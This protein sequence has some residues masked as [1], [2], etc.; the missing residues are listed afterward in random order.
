MAGT[1]LSVLAVCLLLLVLRA[2][3]R[4]QFRH[5]SWLFLGEP[6]ASALDFGPSV[7]AIAHNGGDTDESLA[8]AIAWDA[9][10]VEFDVSFLGGKLDVAHTPPRMTPFFLRA[11]V[12]RSRRLAECWDALPDGLAVYL[13]AKIHTGRSARALAMFL[14]ARPGRRVFV[15]A[16]N[17]AFLAYLKRLH[18][19]ALT[20]LSVGRRQH[21][22]ARRL[23]GA[24]PEIDAVSL[25]HARLLLPEVVSLCHERG[26]VVFA[27]PCN[28]RDALVDYARC[29]ADAVIT[30]DLRVIG[31]VS[32]GRQ[33]R[34]LT[35]LSSAQ[36]ATM[37]TGRDRTAASV[38]SM[39][40][41]RYSGL[42]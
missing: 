10:I 7:I 29:G 15:G 16:P 37:P 21:W 25:S 26:L 40:G 22:L 42:P 8:L 5:R 32:A 23:E 9:D 2:C 35:V 33:K 24:W 18:P 41:D 19:E 28:D 27:G 31:A 30:D 4:H 6:P 36:K 20:V 12:Y 34:S 3:C 14:Q 38:S 13:D 17:P 1:V 39:A 11:L